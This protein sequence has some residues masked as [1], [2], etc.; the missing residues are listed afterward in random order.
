M[1]GPDEGGD[2]EWFRDEAAKAHPYYAE[3]VI[4]RMKEYRV[5]LK[6]DGFKA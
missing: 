1:F 4:P 2:L 6:Q 3:Q 5:N